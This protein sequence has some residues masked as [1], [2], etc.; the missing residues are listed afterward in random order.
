LKLRESALKRIQEDLVAA[1]LSGGHYG[2]KIHVELV[3][4]RVNALKPELPGET[5]SEL[6]A[7]VSLQRVGGSQ[8]G[9]VILRNLADSL[10]S[11]QGN[12]C[13]FEFGQEL[14]NFGDLRLAFGGKMIVGGGFDVVLVRIIEVVNA[15]NHYLGFLRP[16]RDVSVARGNT[17]GDCGL[18]G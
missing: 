3:V 16:G 4:D 12:L 17:S 13:R 1:L 7:L 15:E 8:I 10:D 2:A 11:F 14:D 9:L 5:H 18:A 6:I